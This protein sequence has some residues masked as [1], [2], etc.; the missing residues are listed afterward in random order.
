MRIIEQDA[1]ALYACMSQ[2]LL[3]LSDYMDGV[4]P[5]DCNWKWIVN[6]DLDMFFSHYGDNIEVNPES[7][8]QLKGSNEKKI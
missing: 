3:E 2:Y 1:L 4:N 6:I 8:T 5:E 7:W